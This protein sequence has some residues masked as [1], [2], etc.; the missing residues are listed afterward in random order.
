[1]ENNEIQKTQNEQI[2]IKKSVK[3]KKKTCKNNEK[4]RYF[5]FYDDIKHDSHRDI[6]W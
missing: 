5:D 6:A 1:M 3:N 4:S 2:N